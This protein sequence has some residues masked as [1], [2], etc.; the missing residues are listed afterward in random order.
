MIIPT[1]VIVGA[2]AGYLGSLMV[3]K[4]MSLAGG[5]LGHLALPGIA[6]GLVL[7]VDIFWGALLTTV[8]GALIIWFLDRGRL[9]IESITGI[10]FA[11]GVALGFLFL[12]L[13]KAEEAVIGDISSVGSSE[14][15]I[16]LVVA[17]I[18]FIVMERV[19]S[20]IIMSSLSRSLARSEGINSRKVELLYLLVIALVVAFEVKIVGILLT[21]ALFVIPAS[22]ARILSKN[23]RSYKILSIILGITSTIGGYILY[24]VTDLPAGPLM[25]VVASALFLVSVIKQRLYSIN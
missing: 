24:L 6:L 3:S 25:I 5:P 20:K 23:L 10:V 11:S 1:T 22:T 2:C 12:P 19:Y 4:R 13:E 17:L 21:A 9:P 15:A 7:G 14:L 18:T 8:L 16:G